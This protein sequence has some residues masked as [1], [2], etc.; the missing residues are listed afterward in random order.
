[1]FEYYFR[2][3]ESSCIFLA[4]SNVLDDLIMYPSFPKI[5]IHNIHNFAL[6]DKHWKSLHNVKCNEQRTRFYLTDT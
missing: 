3:F 5:S 1:M 2:L 4:I 6:R